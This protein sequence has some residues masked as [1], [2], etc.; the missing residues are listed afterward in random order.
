MSPIRAEELA[1]SI[2][3]AFNIHRMVSLCERYNYQYE[4]YA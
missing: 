3:G 2:G 1:L 4:L